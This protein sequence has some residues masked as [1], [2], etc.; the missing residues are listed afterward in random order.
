MTVAMRCEQL[1]NHSTG[2]V[3]ERLAAAVAPWPAAPPAP[4]PFAHAP[5]PFAAVECAQQAFAAQLMQAR[6]HVQA[7]AQ[8]QAQA[9]TSPLQSSPPPT[10]IYPYLMPMWPERPPAPPVRFP[11][12]LCT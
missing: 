2:A 10:S 6:A 1:R 8:A 11:C 4:A 9:Q 5:Q 7:Q 3:T 12:S